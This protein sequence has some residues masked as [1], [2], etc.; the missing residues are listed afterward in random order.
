MRPESRLRLE[1]AAEIFHGGPVGDPAKVF[2]AAAFADILVTGWGSHVFSRSDL[3]QFDNLKLIVHAAGSLRYCFPEQNFP[4]SVKVCA[5]GRENARPVAEFT[6]GLILAG[7]R[8]TFSSPQ[9]LRAKGLGEWKSLH[10]QTDGYA[11]RVIAL[12][13]FG[14][15]A[16]NLITLLQPFDFRLL[17]VSDFVTRE[18]ERRFGIRRVS[19]AEAAAAA[20]VLSL[21]EA[22]LPIYRKMI[23]RDVLER[24]PDHAI[25][26]NT[27]R[28]GLIDEKALVEALE[29]RPLTAILDVL[30]EEESGEPLEHHP[31]LGLANCFLTPHIAGSRGLE[32]KRFGDYLVR[33]VERFVANHPLE[34]CLDPAILHQRA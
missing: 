20:D 27:A 21:H 19:L 13:G 8:G 24:M 5:A 10:E 16:K 17:V 9:I 2:G 29:N 25:L 22:D 12:V 15:I 23:N 18:D 3:E 4:Y 1:Q 31:L 6:L 34:N 7:L 30:A 33:E 32:I 26:I 14:D 11:E 28:G